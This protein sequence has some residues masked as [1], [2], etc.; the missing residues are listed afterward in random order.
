[1]HKVTLSKIVGSV[2]RGVLPASWTLRTLTRV[3]YKVRRF[4][5][6][7]FLVIHSVD[8]IVFGLT[9]AFV[10]FQLFCLLFGQL[11]V[12][13]ARKMKRTYAIVLAVYCIQL[14]FPALLE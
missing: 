10:I 12:G 4:A 5:Q 1:M 7:F 6:V 13:H 2:P 3:L 8:R 9:P 11:S 14:P